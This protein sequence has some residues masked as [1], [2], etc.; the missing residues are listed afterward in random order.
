MAAT[1][2]VE[3]S[4]DVE[5]DVDA[6]DDDFKMEDFHGGSGNRM[7]KAVAN[8]VTRPGNSL[9]RPEFEPSKEVQHSN[10]AL[11]MYTCTE[12]YQF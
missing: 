7:N 2:G 12:R 1:N 3:E 4:S 5:R 8:L 11:A 6:G 10:T 9:T